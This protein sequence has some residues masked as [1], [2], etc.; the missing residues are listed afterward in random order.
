VPKKRDDE[1]PATASEAMQKKKRW[2]GSGSIVRKEDGSEVVRN[3]F[4]VQGPK[5]VQGHEGRQRH[6]MST[7]V[8]RGEATPAVK[9]HIDFEL[10][11]FNLTKHL[12]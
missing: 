6:G 3:L 12:Q 7:N 4:I 9:R 5:L 11:I 10:D 8:I 2:Q 1:A